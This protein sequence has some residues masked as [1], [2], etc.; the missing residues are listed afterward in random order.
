MEEKKKEEKKELVAICNRLVEPI[1]S[2]ILTVRGVQVILDR[3]LRPTSASTIAY[4]KLLYE[5]VS[6]F[7]LNLSQ[8]AI[9]PFFNFVNI[10]FLAKNHK[11]R[12]FN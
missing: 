10:R 11:P 6:F 1:E 5:I 4:R 9:V 2:R 7:L 3:D 8:T 12:C